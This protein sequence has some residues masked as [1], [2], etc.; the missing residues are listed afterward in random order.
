MTLRQ[1][2]SILT[3]P[4]WDMTLNLPFLYTIEI[5]YEDK[6]N[7]FQ[8]IVKE[9]YKSHQLSLYRHILTR[10]GKLPQLAKLKINICHLKNAFPCSARNS[11]T[12][13]LQTS[14]F[15]YRYL[16]FGSY[17]TKESFVSTANK[18]LVG[19]LMTVGDVTWASLS[20]DDHICIV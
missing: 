3:L 20:E 11:D 10:C 6:S 2:S 7:F 15:R 12:H 18:P 13:Y 1:S 16:K 19:T 14:L 9:N 5:N 8:K 17:T 4:W